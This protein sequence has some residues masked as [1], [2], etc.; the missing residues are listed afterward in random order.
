MINQRSHHRTIGTVAVFLLMTG[1]ASAAL[2]NFVP[3]GM[4]LGLGLLSGAAGA[5]GTY[6]WELRALEKARL[7]AWREATAPGPS[8]E[9]GWES[10]PAGDSVLAMLN[11][12]RRVVTFNRLRTPERESLRAFFDSGDRADRRREEWT[13]G[14]RVRLL[15]GGAGL[16]KTR[17]LVEATSE[18]SYE[19][20]PY[21]GWIA[22]G[23]ENEALRAA[24]G[25]DRP[26]VLIIDDAETR[27]DLAEMLKSLARK[28]NA[29]VRVVLAAR[30]F[31]PWWARVLGTLDPRTTVGLLGSAHI[32]VGPLVT[33]PHDLQQLFTQA[34][35][36][37]AKCFGTS[38]PEATL[39]TANAATPLV[40]VHAAAA[41]AAHQGLSG[42]VDIDTAVA[43]L[44]DI[45]EEWWERL[46]REQDLE[47]GRAK[48][49][50]AVVASVLV[51]AADQAAAERLMRHLPGLDQARPD[52]VSELALLVRAFYPQRIGDW[53][54]PHLPGRLVERYVADQL[55]AAPALQAALVAAALTE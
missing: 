41:M 30:D 49:R 42:P 21:C 28:P 31:G 29:D 20:A 37:Y 32:E 16:G 33:T 5:A 51:G 10:G 55:A 4:A 8:G 25:W 53:L 15:R 52:I 12:E 43:G 14:D 48:L 35:R 54:D 40:L 45:E 34:V 47:V 13:L 17:L 22:P 46:A 6:A 2:A 9:P 23:K 3:W 19:S 39:A 44:F 26:A 36:D 1:G 27:P 24:V 38:P 7:H 11:P 50:A 18:L